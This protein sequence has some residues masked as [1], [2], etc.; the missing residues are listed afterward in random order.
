MRTGIPE[1]EAL[2]LLKGIINEHGPGVGLPNAFPD[3][4]IP[5]CV[6]CLEMGM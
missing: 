5:E 6:S 1:S 2:H 3:V 4:F